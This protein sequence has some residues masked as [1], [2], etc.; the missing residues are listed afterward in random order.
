MPPG[1]VD[2]AQSPQKIVRNVIPRV[3]LEFIDQSLNY[4]GTF[5]VEILWRLYSLRRLTRQPPL[6]SNS[7][8]HGRA[9]WVKSRPCDAGLIGTIIPIGSLPCQNHFLSAQL[10]VVC[11]SHRKSHLLCACPKPSCRIVK[12]GPWEKLISNL[13]NPRSSVW[14]RIQDHP[15]WREDY[16]VLWRGGNALI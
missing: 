14:S 6:V 13:S 16:L 4:L 7:A 8:R 15:A 10:R 9:G 3:E 5:R 11:A 2:V 1:A 12:H